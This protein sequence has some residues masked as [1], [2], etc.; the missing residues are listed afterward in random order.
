MAN[1]TPFFFICLIVFNSTFDYQG[2]IL[3]QFYRP[4]FIGNCFFQNNLRL[5]SIFWQ[6]HSIPAKQWFRQLGAVS[7]AHSKRFFWN[8]L[9]NMTG[10]R[11]RSKREHIA[12]IHFERVDYFSLILIWFEILNF[13]LLLF[14]LKIN[15]S[16]KYRRLILKKKND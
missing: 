10:L 16:F 1:L 13:F 6:L 15:I 4:E 14:Y 11:Y 7:D 5:S 9:R 3:S 12:I 2:A 8:A